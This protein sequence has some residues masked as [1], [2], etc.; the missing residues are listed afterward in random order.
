ML[1]IQK[2][3]KSACLSL[4]FI[5]MIGNIYSQTS[6]ANIQLI[7][8]YKDGIT[9]FIPIGGAG[10]QSGLTPPSNFSAQYSNSPQGLLI[11]WD[12]VS[13]AQNYDVSRSIDE[14]ATWDDAY[15]SVT[16]PEF[17][18]TD[19]HLDNS[20]YYYRVRSCSDTCGSWSASPSSTQQ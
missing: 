9:I 11:S 2:K 16:T 4:F 12:A 18:D 14:G 5:T 19:I 7:P 20:T 15:G 6:S 3:L 10:G 13:E 17:L 1:R 8:I